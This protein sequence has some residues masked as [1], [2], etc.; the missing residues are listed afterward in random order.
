MVINLK[1]QITAAVDIF[2]HFF[3]VKIRLQISC[4]STADYSHEMASL[5]FF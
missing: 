2:F 4:K 3:S 5:I 1:V